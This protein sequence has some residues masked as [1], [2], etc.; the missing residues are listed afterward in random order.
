MSTTAAIASSAR[1]RRRVVGGEVAT[2]A[3]SWRAGTTCL[4]RA[5]TTGGGYSPRGT[6]D[7]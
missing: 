6:G 7:G 2:L 3:L 1:D 4:P 5:D